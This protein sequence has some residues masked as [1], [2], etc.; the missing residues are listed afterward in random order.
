MPLSIQGNAVLC[1]MWDSFRISYVEKNPGSNM[2]DAERYFL[3]TILGGLVNDSDYALAVYSNEF[4]ETQDLIE[5][6]R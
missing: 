4:K 1:K 3:Y 5:E 6:I 2:N